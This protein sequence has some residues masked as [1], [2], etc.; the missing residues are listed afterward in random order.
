MAFAF[1]QEFHNRRTQISPAMLLSDLYAKT[2]LLP[3]FAL[4]PYGSQHIAHLLQ[5]IEVTRALANRGIATLAALNRF[6]EFQDS[7]GLENETAFPSFLEEHESAVRLLT[8]HQAKGL[9]FSVVILADA[10]YQQRR[11]SRTGIIERMDGRMELRIGAR[12]L[13]CSTLGWQKAEAQEQEREVAEERR[14][15]YVA[16]TRG[17]DHL[18]IPIVLPSGGKTKMKH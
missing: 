13:T 10:A 15:W 12:N 14:L 7:T 16:A 17:R 8:I 18:V 2:H 3:L 4:H 1:L 6:L 5:L 9:E 11:S